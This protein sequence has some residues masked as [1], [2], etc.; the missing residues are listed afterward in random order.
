M[1]PVI[2]ISD[3]TFVDLKS[4]ATW[5]GTDTPS[6]TIENLVREKMSALDLERDLGDEQ[7]KEVAKEGEIT[8]FERAPGLTF[9]RIL[10]A[11]VKSKS[12]DKTNW[13]GLLIEMA[14]QVKAKGITT[15]GLS[16]ELQIPTK[17]DAYEEEGYRFYPELGISVQGQ[18]AQ[19]AWKEVS[20]LA[21][22]H[23]IPVEIEFQ[24]RD[25]ENAQHPG[26]V[27]IIQAGK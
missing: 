27:G 10:S 17:L 6:K 13:A 25:N 7:I 8:I 21:D 26:K 24:W 22:K 14:K 2:R 11:T 18:S 23:R 19:D 9:T 4:I 3:A 5:V 20:R 12:L 1:M 15:D 16:K